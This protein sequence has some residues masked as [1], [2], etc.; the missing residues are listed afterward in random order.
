MIGGILLLG[1][2]VF[3]LMVLFGQGKP[4]DYYK[5][6]IWL[7]FA[8]VLLAIGYNHA[9]WYW[10][11][12]PLWMQIFS[13]LLVPFFVSAALKLMFPKAKWL[14]GLQA[15]LFQTLI[16][17]VTFPVRFVWRSG[18]FLFH[19]ERRPAQR[20]NPYRPVVGGRPPLHNE[21]RE[22]QPGRNIFD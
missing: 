7:I 5:F 20:L 18:Q 15:A 1:I 11:G 12:L 6:L 9:L 2:A 19:R 16:Y 21:R 3:G 17:V 10:L 4:E 22:V 8:P 14:P 13:V